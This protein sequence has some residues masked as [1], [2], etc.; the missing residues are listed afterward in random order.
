MEKDPNRI[1]QHAVGAKLDS[2][3]PMPL[4]CLSDFA[5]AF[6]QLVGHNL[7]F[8]EIRPSVKES[9]NSVLASDL[10]LSGSVSARALL[11]ALILVQT[12]INSLDKKHID[13]STL[14]GLISTF[15]HAILALS[16]LTA[17]GAKKYRPS[18]WKDV[19][20]GINRYSEACARH[21]VRSK[22]E[23]ADK[24]TG[25]T[26]LCCVAWNAA[27]ALTLSQAAH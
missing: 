8:L 3:K 14:D 20:D 2:E 6:Q 23:Q 12:S 15:P 10:F 17:I 27:A 11:A 24:D 1:E 16:T 21:F 19:E 18:G 26:H 9:C 22:I 7:H 5:P 13:L 4:L 25:A